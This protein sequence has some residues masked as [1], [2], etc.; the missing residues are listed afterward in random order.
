MRAN[1]PSP[2][3]SDSEPLLSVLLS[4]AVAAAA[5]IVIAGVLWLGHDSY[6]LWR[7]N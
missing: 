4:G 5:F 1:R 3:R 6:Q 2:T 7:G